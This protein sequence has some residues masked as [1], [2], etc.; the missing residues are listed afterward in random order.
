ME[1]DGY[2]VKCKMK[3]H[4]VDGEEVIKTVKGT[5]RKFVK[6]HCPHCNTAVWKVLGKA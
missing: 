4:V 3:V 5:K 1:F 6:G 2:C